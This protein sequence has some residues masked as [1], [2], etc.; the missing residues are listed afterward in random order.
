MRRKEISEFNVQ[1]TGYADKEIPVQTFADIYNLVED[2]NK[3]NETDKVKIE[4][5]RGGGAIS[6]L[7]G[8]NLSGYLDA[9]PTMEKF[10]S[11]FFGADNP[12]DYFFKFN[13]SE[14]EYDDYGRINKIT[15]YMYKKT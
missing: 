4:Y 6:N 2:W 5:G 10:L 13:S 14:T 15:M 7:N 12:N 9:K 3:Q 1:F 11:D 8:K